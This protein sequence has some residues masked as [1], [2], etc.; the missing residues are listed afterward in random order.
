MTPP[1]FHQVAFV[2]DDLDA[3]V[4]H[5]ADSLGVGPWSV[6]T[7]TPDV[8]HDT[9][10]HGEPA[11]FGIR[12]GLA[13]SGGV[14]FELVEPIEGPSIFADQLAASGAGLNHV[15][16]LVEDHAAESAELVAQG[17]LPLQS[18]R[19]GESADGRFAYFRSPAGDAIVELIQPP[20]RRFAADYIYPEPEA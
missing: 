10:Y 14:Q 13:W 4:R 9:V 11:R 20:T 18:A 17:Y 16:R 5:W 8:L 1:P 7:M 15:G 3:A 12:H 19:F 6:W 2:V